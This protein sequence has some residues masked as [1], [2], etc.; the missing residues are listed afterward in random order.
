MT[1]GDFS[2]S[3]QADAELAATLETVHRDRWLH[4]MLTSTLNRE[5][6]RILA[7]AATTRAAFAVDRFPDE[8]KITTN[9]GA[10]ALPVPV[11]VWLEYERAYRTTHSPAAGHCLPDI[12]PTIALT[13]RYSYSNF[14]FQLLIEKSFCAGLSGKISEAE[15]LDR[16][17]YQLARSHNFPV[18][19]FRA[20]GFLS[21]YLVLEGLYREAAELQDR[22]L[23]LFWSR[24]FPYMRGQEYYNSHLRIDEAL[25]RLYSAQAAAEMSARCAQLAGATVTEAVANA[26]WAEFEERTNLNSAARTH[27]EKA[28]SL[29]SRLA[30]NNTADEYRA[31]AE[32]KA[33]P[34]IAKKDRRWSTSKAGQILHSTNPLLLVPLRNSIA[35]AEDTEGRSTRAESYLE[36]SLQTLKNH[37]SL[38]SATSQQLWRSAISDTY[39]ELVRH[40]LLRGANEDAYRLWQEYLE[41][42]ASLLGSARAPE[43]PHRNE[44]K[45][46]ITF[47][48][49]A[50]RYAVWTHVDKQLTFD[51]LDNAD[52]VDRNVRRFAFLCADPKSDP[53]KIRQ[54]G[55]RLMKDLIGTGIR[56]SGPRDPIAIQPDDEIWDVPWN[57]LPSGDR[58]WVGTTRQVAIVSDPHYSPAAPKPVHIALVVAATAIDERLCLKETGNRCLVHTRNVLMTPYRGRLVFGSGLKTWCQRGGRRGFRR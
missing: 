22:M 8:L 4:D 56:L 24:P 12:D 38:N 2:A 47:A 7:S 19:E 28:Q 21:G 33:L 17:A 26:L 42:D 39:R 13:R 14:L 27:W 46:L 52:E 10:D 44:P 9:L 32:A 3:D 35:E 34:V 6:I 51:W 5:A 1:L 49:L 20:G 15:T 30:T 29:F 48:R 23:Q 57:A 43:I 37:S 41:T 58:D 36:D 53:Y 54:V 40:R 31:Y 18:A 45:L 16:E 11:R 50:N 55:Q 25:G